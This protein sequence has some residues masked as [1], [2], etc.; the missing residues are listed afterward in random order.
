MKN[1]LT[2][3]EKRHL[4]TVDIHDTF[5]VFS[6]EEYYK[7]NYV[8]YYKIV[9]CKLKNLS[10]NGKALRLIGS[11]AKTFAANIQSFISFDYYE[12]NDTEAMRGLNLSCQSLY[13]NFKSFRV[14]EEKLFHFNREIKY[15]EF[16]FCDL[17][18]DY[19][20]LKDYYTFEA[21]HKGQVTIVEH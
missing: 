16:C 21:Y 2:A 5:I 6:M 18:Q 20:S 3:K 9:E 14:S 12:Q 13:L 4:K 11:L 1:P 8:N 10:F 17:H 15:A 19:N 7:G